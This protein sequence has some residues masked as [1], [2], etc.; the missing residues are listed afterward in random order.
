MDSFLKVQGFGVRVYKHLNG[1]VW[2]GGGCLSHLQDKVREREEKL[3]AFA[4]S[5]AGFSLPE[6]EIFT[7]KLLVRIYFIIVMIRW[8]G[9][10]PWEASAFYI[11]P[12]VWTQPLYLTSF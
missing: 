9:L 10:A 8:T 5:R 4:C 6:Q 3:L 7:D 12:L 11:Y 2:E 1:G